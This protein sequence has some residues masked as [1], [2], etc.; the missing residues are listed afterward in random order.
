MPKKTNPNETYERPK[1][2]YNSVKVVLKIA[3]AEVEFD[4]I[5]NPDGS[6]S[7]VDPDTGVSIIDYATVEHFEL[8]FRNLNASW[9]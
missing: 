7:L 6:V 3:D 4:A 8:H 9:G 1:E 5:K 2:L